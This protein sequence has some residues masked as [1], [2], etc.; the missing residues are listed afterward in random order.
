[1][2][3]FERSEAVRLNRALAS[4][5]AR[6]KADELIF[7]GRVF[8]NGIQ[9]KNPARRVGPEDVV[10]LDGKKVPRAR[11]PLCLML[12]KPVGVVSTA[13]DP[14]GRPTVL[15]YVPENLRGARLYPVGRLD[16]FSEGL[17]LLTNDGALAQ[18]LAHPGGGHEKRYEVLVCGAVSESALKSMRNGMTLS[19]GIRLAPMGATKREIG[20]NTL[21]TLVLHQ[22]L[23]RQIRRVCR[24]LGLTIL[25]LRRVAQGSLWLGDLAPGK[26]RLLTDE[27]M[28][29]FI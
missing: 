5:C 8:V 2:I 6:R 23:N 7:A 18:K 28:A 14:E 20:E 25:K 16:F 17:L 15:D 22:G 26:T 1:M 9:E 29:E 13:R 21:L 12:N 24:D 19:D 27:E 11:K 10:E 4:I 3:D